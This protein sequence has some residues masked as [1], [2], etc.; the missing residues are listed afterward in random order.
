MIEP[1]LIAA[2]GPVRAHVGFAH[3]AVLRRTGIFLDGEAADDDS[4]S[5]PLRAAAKGILS[6]RGLELVSGGV[7]THVD[8]IGGVVEEERPGGHRREAQDPPQQHVVAKYVLRVAASRPR[9]TFSHIMAELLGLIAGVPSGPAPDPARQQPGTREHGS[10]VADE[11]LVRFRHD[12]LHPVDPGLDPE[13]GARWCRV[14]ASL[15]IVARADRRGGPSA[16][17]GVGHDR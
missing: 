6:G 10:R 12:G 9:G 11:L 13:H 1:D 3:G 17:G 7:V 5:H 2:Q 15:D 8:A 4:G 14:D 16:A